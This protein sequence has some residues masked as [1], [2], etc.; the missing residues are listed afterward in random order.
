MCEAP[1]QRRR[2]A[3]N[4]AMMAQGSMPKPRASPDFSATRSSHPSLACRTRGWSS[5]GST[6][7]SIFRDGSRRMSVKRPL[8]A[9]ARL[10]DEARV[11]SFS[12]GFPGWGL[13]RAGLGQSGPAARLEAGHSVVTPSDRHDPGPV[14]AATHRPCPLRCRC[15]SATWRAWRFSPRPPPTGRRFVLSGVFGRQTC[16]LGRLVDLGGIGII[17]AGYV[18]VI[19]IFLAIR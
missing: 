15:S 8:D 5:N 12:G 7:H 14:L 19:A 16:A 17:L 9:A 18:L 10:R 4:S 2:P 13:E 6:R 3:E 11:E 1:P